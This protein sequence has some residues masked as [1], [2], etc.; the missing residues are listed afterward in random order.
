[1]T[2]PKILIVEDNIPTAKLIQ[3]QLKDKNY[4]ISEIV[5]SGMEVIQRIKQDR[6]DLVLMDILL[7]G[8]MNGIQTADICNQYNVPVVYITAYED[9]ELFYQA[10]ETKP[11][12]YLL[13]PFKKRDLFTAVEIALGK[14]EDEQ[15]LRES[16]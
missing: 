14:H 13:K 6:P 7:E 2:S 11:F 3:K 9:E 15:K 12:G 5:T 4:G 16:A 1:M 10:K 8:D